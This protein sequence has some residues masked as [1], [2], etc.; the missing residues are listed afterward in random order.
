[1][2]K[3]YWYQQEAVDS[4]MHHISQKIIQEMLF[5]QVFNPFTKRLIF[6]AKYQP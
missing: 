4:T 5:T 2:L 1:M 3:P 6:S